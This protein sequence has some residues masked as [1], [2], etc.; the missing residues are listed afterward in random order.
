[1]VPTGTRPWFNGRVG[2][3]RAI[4]VLEKVGAEFKVH[5]YH[6]TTSGDTYGETVAAAI[7][8]DG[9]RV[10]KTLIAT[11]DDSPAVGIVPVDRRLSLKALAR[12]AGGKRAHMAETREAERLTGYVVGGISPFGRART[13]PV[14]VD[15]SAFDHGTIYVSGGRRGIQLEISPELLVRVLDGRPAA[16]SD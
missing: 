13:L 14:F 2:K 8:V 3:T 1:M 7:G 15:E 6:A 5:Y 12:A 11:V 16:I 4:Q 10:F 9:D